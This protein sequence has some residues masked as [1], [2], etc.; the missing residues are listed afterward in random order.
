MSQ[1]E[2]E[3]RLSR[4]GVALDEIEAATREAAGHDVVE[5]GYARGNV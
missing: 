2:G 1:L 4:S 5:T 3:C